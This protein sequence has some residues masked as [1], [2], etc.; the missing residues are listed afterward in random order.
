[1]TDGVVQMLRTLKGE[2]VAHATFHPDGTIQSVSF[3]EVQP[4]SADLDTQRDESENAQSSYPRRPTG[5]LIP[6]ERLDSP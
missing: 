5:G 4:P 1:M 2:G 6:R 3:V